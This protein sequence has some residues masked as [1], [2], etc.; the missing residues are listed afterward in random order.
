M[1]DLFGF[2]PGSPPSSLT[3]HA[4]GSGHAVWIPG[5]FTQDIGNLTPA[6]VAALD[7]M[8]AALRSHAPPKVSVTGD[9]TLPS[10]LSATET[11][12][13]RR[14]GADTYLVTNFP[15]WSDKFPPKPGTFSHNFD[16]DVANVVLEVPATGV[17]E[18]WDAQTGEVTRLWNYTVTLEGRLRVPLSL[19][20]FGSRVLRLNPALDPATETHITATNLLDASI[21]GAGHVVGYAPLGLTGAAFA[22][23]VVAGT[24]THV[25]LATPATATSSVYPDTVYDVE[26]TEGDH[27]ARKAGSWNALSLDPPTAPRTPW[28]SDA[29]TYTATIEVPDADS[30]DGRV[31][32]DLGGVGDAGL[33]KLNGQTLGIAE[34]PPYAYEVTGA[35]QPGGDALSVRVKMSRAGGFPT[36]DPLWPAGLLGPVTSR[37]EPLVDLG[38]PS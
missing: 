27:V 38:L 30:D 31:I 18:L 5:D 24:S 10:G 32:L 36:G 16:S 7:P 28:Y 14:A 23:V 9:H 34:F 6:R 15:K 35:A 37:F 8:I 17:P 21:N 25:E 4:H 3:D 20:E 13:Y 19:P 2:A 1:T 33:V 29:G 26:W 11:Y 12:P 22:D